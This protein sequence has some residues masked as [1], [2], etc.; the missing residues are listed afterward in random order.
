[1]TEE[2]RKS[3]VAGIPLASIRSDTVCLVIF[4]LSHS[5]GARRRTGFG[6]LGCLCC[7]QE[8][9]KEQTEILLWECVC[10]A[11]L[12]GRIMDFFVCL[13]V[14]WMLARSITASF[15]CYLHNM[16]FGS[17]S[18]GF[19]GRGIGQLS[20]YVGSHT[21]A[22]HGFVLE[23]ENCVIKWQHKQHWD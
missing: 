12:Q 22:G 11:H 8:Q 4:M 9:V 21:H 18:F 14:F 19:C 13:F 10:C 5:A 20:V 3:D 2:I 16:I 17:C 15:I 7:W 6:G 1:M 23:V